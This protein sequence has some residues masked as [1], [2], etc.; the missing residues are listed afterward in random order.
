MHKSFIVDEANEYHLVSSNKSWSKSFCTLL[1]SYDP[2]GAELV[3]NAALHLDSEVRIPL[4][5]EAVQARVAVE[6][7]IMTRRSGRSW[8]ELPLA[9]E[10]LGR[11]L[12]LGNGIQKSDERETTLPRR[13]VP[14][15]GGLG[16]VEI[17]CCILNVGGI[18]QGLYHFDSVDHELRLIK[19]GEYSYWIRNCLILQEEFASA[20]AI[21]FLIS[22]Q[23]RLATK[24]GARAY[25]IGLM[26]V[27]HVSQ[28]IYLVA[29]A[30]GLEVCATAGFIDEELNS[31]LNLDGIDNCALLA[32]AVGERAE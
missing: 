28:N 18:A 14:S 11:I 19:A 2:K 8:S 25:R 26:D 7:A 30:L 13:N 1:Q 12:Y 32:L 20:S 5:V 6:D 21:M 17:Y 29:T 22:S 16:S 3:M 23:K 31:A 10:K 9:A 15:S 4:E 24:Y 27:G